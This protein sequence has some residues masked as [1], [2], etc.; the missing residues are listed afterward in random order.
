[1]SGKKPVNNNK[2]TIGSGFRMASNKQVQ[3]CKR[4]QGEQQKK[5]EEDAKKKFISPEKKPLI[6]PAPVE[7]HIIS[8]DDEVEDV[9][10]QFSEKILPQVP[11]HPLMSV[12]AQAQQQVENTNPLLGTLSSVV[13]DAVAN[14][15]PPQGALIPSQQQDDQLNIAYQHQSQIP[16]N[17]DK[18][19]DDE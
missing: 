15:D 1:M 17:E 6:N 19:D 8:I 7:K 4:K 2:N 12:D 11:T 3:D 5:K 10:N 14:N 13:T 16:N 18:A 9:Q